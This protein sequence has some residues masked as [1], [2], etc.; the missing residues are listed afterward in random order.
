[1]SNQGAKNGDRPNNVVNGDFKRGMSNG[2][3]AF[4]TFLVC[5]LL[6]PFL[7]GLIVLA[8]TF[9]SGLLQMGPPSLKGLGMAALAPRAGQWALQS[10]VWAALPAALAGAALAAVVSMRGTFHWF[11]AAAAA[12]A[13][14][15]V[16]AVLA[17]GLLANH[18]VFLAVIAGLVGLA[19]RAVL[20]RARII[21]D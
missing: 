16:A 7:V 5:T 2:Q 9:A 14:F 11:V 10:F 18:H 21:A 3:R 17:P 6:G 15:G 12:I 4:W 19:C 20:R 1:M 13:G 8:L